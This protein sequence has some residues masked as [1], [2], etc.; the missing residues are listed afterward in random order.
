[1]HRPVVLLV[2]ISPVCVHDMSAEFAPSLNISQ[3]KWTLEEG[4]G[5]SGRDRA[6]PS[7]LRDKPHMGEIAPRFPRTRGSS[8][9]LGTEVPETLNQ[10][11]FIH[12]IQ[13]GSFKI[14]LRN[15]AGNSERQEMRSLLLRSGVSEKSA[16]F[17]NL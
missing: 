13:K 1:M 5:G 10:L 2:C 9:S 15:R 6:V 8:L 3:N 12:F 7:P 4:H 11:C 16:G 17:N 14:Q